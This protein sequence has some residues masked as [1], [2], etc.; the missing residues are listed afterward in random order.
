MTVRN[1]RSL[2]APEHVLLLGTPG[3]D[4]AKQLHHNI[5]H[6]VPAVRRTLVGAAEAGWNAVA[7]DARWPPAELAVMMDR[8]H[9]TPATILRLADAGCRA[10]LWPM[11]AD[12]P[13][14]LLEAMRPTTMRLLGPR[15]GGSCLTR[16]GYNLSSLALTPHP[17]NVALIAQS[18]SVAAAAVDWAVGRNVGLSWLAVT[19]GEA[20]IDVADLLDHAALD[21]ETRA[22]ALQLSRIRAPR[23]F[24]SAARAAARVKPVV[25]LQTQPLSGL[26]AGSAAVR[27]A[28]FQRAGLV[29]CATLG[30]LFDAIAALGRLPAPADGRVVVVGN[31]AGAC[32]LAVDALQ[33]QNL[34]ATQ[35]PPERALELQAIAPQIRIAGGAVDLGQASAPVTVEALRLLLAIPRVDALLY[36]HSPD[37]RESHEQIAGALV[38]AGL[39]ERLLTV[40]LGL[41]TA[42]AARGIAG[43]GGLATFPSADE[44][45][46]ALRY[47]R[48]H[49][50]TRELLMQ[51]PPP[52]GD[53][54]GREQ[55]V[56]AL[57]QGLPDEGALPEAVLEPMLAAYGLLPLPAEPQLRVGLS[58]A[59]DPELG[60]HLRVTPLVEG[61]QRRE[62][63]G[64]PPLDPLLA[65]RM[66]TDAG[67]LAD[68]AAVTGLQL[69]QALIRLGQL[70]ID[71]PSIA[72]LGLAL[73]VGVDGSVGLLAGSASATR[74]LPLPDRQRLP[75]APYP[76][77]LRHRLPLRDGQALRIRAVRPADEP[78]V[79]GLLQRL[80]PEEVRLRF[81]HLIRNFSHDLGARMTQVDYDREIC[82]V[83]LPE[84]HSQQIVVI[85]TLVSDPDGAAAEFAVLVHHDWAG[86]GIGKHMLGR[87]VE[88]ARSRA[89]GT[90]FGEVL[91]ENTPMLRL[92]KSLGFLSQRDPEDPGCIRVSLR[93]AG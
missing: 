29:E 11:A 65:R 40:W 82:L 56:H 57:L 28:A 23:K 78:A 45:A 33:R 66:L 71:Q 4:G 58:A 68:G 80:D 86:Q 31:G 85:A 7:E 8:R 22:V 76:S 1:L 39:R 24:M 18:Q 17:G 55:E 49:R 92:S 30:G 69:P 64:F 3:S 73:G 84:D 21:P 10:L 70:V 19:G 53:H 75:L 27:S 37:T 91:A 35:L 34:I 51:T 83:G 77:Q 12:P 2:L 67:L 81:F 90:V 89:I 48:Q 62:A 63:V 36:V 5:A 54:T 15:G 20:D 43:L 42:L 38:A 93:T 26:G 87:L 32:A 79:I 59:L 25:V 88:I 52:D 46:R 13:P 60:M 14:A 50:L 61:L 72:Q 74:R 16:L 44:A 6:T 9:A 41:E 47:G